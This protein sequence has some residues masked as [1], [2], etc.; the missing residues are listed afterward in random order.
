MKRI[1][2]V[3]F[4]IFSWMGLAA[5]PIDIGLFQDHLVRAAVVY[6]SSGNYQL[7]IDGE[8]IRRFEE[9]NILYL[10][11][12]EGQVKVLDGERDF[13][14]ADRVELR[15]LSVES[16]L[17]VRPISPELDSRLY[18]D[19]LLVI[20]SDRYLTLV[21]QVD[22][23]KYLAGVIE[24][25]AGPNSDKEFYKAQSILCRTFALKE[26]D[27]HL[28][29][30]FSLCDG[31]HCQAFKGKSTK[32]PEILEAIVETSGIILADY[33]F[34]LI[35]AAYHA[36][37]G[38]QTQRASDVWLTDM[39]YLQSVV[40]PYSL[41]QP[42]AKWQDTISFADWKAYLLK[43]GMK[44]VSKIPDEIIY[45]EQMRRKKYFI[46][47]KDSI[48]MSK[49]REDWGFKSSFFDMFP[50]GDSV[51][52]WGKG[53]GHGIGMSQEGAMKMARD[54]FSYQ[55]ILKFYFNDV[56]IMDYRDLP[57]SSLPQAVLDR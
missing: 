10:T 40:D 50:S 34:K 3:I 33:N 49:I 7:L 23:D 17:R 14:Y 36:N 22:L 57:D 4:I 15:S 43:N 30:G 8:L 1:V 25:E 37:S 38:G 29:E 21:N 19:N 31:S 47:D 35:T 5:Q 11:L 6:C 16:V 13:G 42:L 9:G 26:M 48:R 41:H 54:G 55:D 53:V 45:V 28:S 32:N 2:T 46:L 12:E 52:V 20:A 24:A 56:R 18:D 27:R 39:D 51:L 44:S